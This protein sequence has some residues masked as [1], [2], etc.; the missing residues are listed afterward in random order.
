MTR[1]EPPTANTPTVKTQSDFHRSYDLTVSDAA[2]QWKKYMKQL[3]SKYK[4]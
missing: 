1:W 3:Q 4:N 2:Q